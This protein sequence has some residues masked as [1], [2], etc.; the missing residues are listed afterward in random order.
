MNWRHIGYAIA[1]VGALASHAASAQGVVEAPV[2]TGSIVVPDL[3]FVPTSTDEEKYPRNFYAHKS[4]VSFATALSDFRDCERVSAV[5]QTPFSI[6]SGFVPFDPDTSS[7]PD[8][9][10]R[11]N[12]G[13]L[14]VGLADGLVSR[15]VLLANRRECLMYKGY[16][17][18]GVTSQSWEAIEANG[19]EEALRI[20]AKIASGG[21]PVQPVAFTPAEAY[22]SLPP[23]GEVAAQIVNLRKPGSVTLDPNLAYILVRTKVPKGAV[24]YNLVLVRELSEDE[25]SRYETARSEALAKAKNPKRF[26]FVYEDLSNVG[27]YGRRIA[28]SGDEQYLL[29]EALSGTYLVAG[30]G[31][32]CLCLGSV[33]FEAQAGRITDLGYFFSGRVTRPSEIPELAPLVNRSKLRS[34]SLFIMA[35]ALRPYRRDMPVP[36]ELKPLPRAGAAYQAVGPLPNLF[37]VSISR[38][39]PVP[40]ILAYDEGV[41]IDARTGMKMVS[42]E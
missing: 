40:G 24:P 13:G 31:N 22:P 16:T 19:P 7:R 39:A 11:F 18:Y 5:T 38:L 42:A 6:P 32:V 27:G 28:E 25:R 8:F 20:R 10:R 34:H 41:V 9:A 30:T 12:G 21:T 23:A 14:I 33:K 4:G 15:N 29:Y 1:F 37:G 26:R 35:S 3:A 36:E 17:L 2:D